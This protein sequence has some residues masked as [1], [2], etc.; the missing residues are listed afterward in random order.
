MEEKKMG[1]K[2]PK[3]SYGKPRVTKHRRNKYIFQIPDFKKL[4][5]S[6]NTCDKCGFL[7]TKFVFS[8]N[9]HS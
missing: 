4:E 3:L 1:G 8:G 6:S 9:V 5:I 2:L 7:N